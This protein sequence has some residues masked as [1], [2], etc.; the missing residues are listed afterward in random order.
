MQEGKKALNVNWINVESTDGK[1]KIT[2][3]GAFIPR[4]PGA[5]N[6]VVGQVACGRTRWKIENDLFNVLKSN[7]SSLAYHFGHGQQYPAMVFAAMI[8]LTF[9]SHTV[10]DCLDGLW[11]HACQAKGSRKRFFEHLRTLAAYLAFPAWSIFMDTRITSKP[12]AATLKIRRFRT[13]LL[14]LRPENTFLVFRSIAQAATRPALP[15]AAWRRTIGSLPRVNK[16][17]R[18]DLELLFRLSKT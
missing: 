10:C 12:P 9:A 13:I 17:R 3:D 1:G 8:L 2:D 14:L 4:L 5:Q 6:N 18:A 11:Q 16:G 7:G 15:H